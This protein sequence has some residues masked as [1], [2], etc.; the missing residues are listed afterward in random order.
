MAQAGWTDTEL[1]FW[2][3]RDKD[4]VE[5]DVVITRGREVWGVEVKAAATVVP[6]DGRGLR[7]LADVA[8]TG[9][10]GGVILHAG[11]STLPTSD[12]RNLAVPLSK[13]WTT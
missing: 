3:Y 4:Q 5:V 12:P 6:Q 10:Q 13:L 2:H 11:T 1:R 7:R 8:G 9:Y